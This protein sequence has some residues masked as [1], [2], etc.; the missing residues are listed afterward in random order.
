RDI[1]WLI[2]TAD[3]SVIDTGVVRQG[4]GAFSPDRRY[5]F[6]GDGAGSSESSLHK[7]DLDNDS[8]LHLESVRPGHTTV[9][10][11]RPLDASG[12][13]TRLYW[14]TGMFDQD[15]NLLTKTPSYVIASTLHG[16]LFFTQGRIH[17]G[18]TGVELGVL[19]ASS[20]VM[21]VTGDQSKLYQF[22]ANSNA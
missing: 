4:D 17:D 19:P 22:T 18:N 12:D 16:E 15:L 2:D 7:F 10:S 20:P 11:S 1:I 21:A 13:G 6:H 9:S 14:G 3:G 8:L 5:Y